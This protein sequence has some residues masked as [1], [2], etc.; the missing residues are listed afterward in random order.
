MDHVLSELMTYAEKLH[1]LAM[2]TKDADDRPKYD[3]RLAALV[4][5]F[6][7]VLKSESQERLKELIQA[8]IRREGLDFFPKDAVAAGQLDKVRQSFFKIFE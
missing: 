6:I 4:P 1:T 3:Q 2:N 8:E 5:I 7:A